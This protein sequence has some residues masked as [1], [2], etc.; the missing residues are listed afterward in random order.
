MFVQQF[1]TGYSYLAVFLLMPAESACIPIPS[2]LIMLFGGALAAD[3]IPGHPS[4]ILVMVAGVAGNVAGSYVAWVVGRYGGQ[5]I[6]HRWGGYVWLRAHDLDPAERWFARYGASAV[7]IGRLLP[8]VRTF[9]SL[10]AGISAMPPIRFGVYTTAGCIPWTAALAGAGYAL[11]RDWQIIAD[12]LHGPVCVI[13]GVVVALLVAGL[14]V[15]CHRRRTC[16][17]GWSTPTDL[18]S[19]RPAWDAPATASAA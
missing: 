13:S 2:E 7:F 3:A 12:A 8:A 4:L 14:A 15:F 11:D 19:R 18:S 5:S 6:W 10:P 1:I 9:I 16:R 17:R